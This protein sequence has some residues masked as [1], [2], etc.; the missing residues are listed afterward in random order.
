MSSVNHGFFVASL[1]NALST[2]TLTFSGWPSLCSHSWIISFLCFNT[3]FNAVSQKSFWVFFPLDFTMTSSLFYTSWLSNI[4]SFL[5]NCFGS[6][7]NSPDY[8]LDL[9]LTKLDIVLMKSSLVD[10]EVD[11]DASGHCHAER[12]KISWLKPQFQL[13]KGIG[14]SVPNITKLQ[15]V[16]IILKVWM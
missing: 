6:P 13:N 8:W 16:Q 5:P 15:L 9:G 7:V 10:L 4:L 14:S 3:E 12:G 1:T 11:L 2:R